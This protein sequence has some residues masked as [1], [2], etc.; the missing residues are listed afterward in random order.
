MI[1]AALLGWR[2]RDLADRF[3][4]AVV[5]LARAA[6]PNDLADDPVP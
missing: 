5:E 1:H 2:G 6:H 3:S 4:A